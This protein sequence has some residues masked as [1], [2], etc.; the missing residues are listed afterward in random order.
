M[1]AWGFYYCRDR[2]ADISLRHENGTAV[3]IIEKFGKLPGSVTIEGGVFELQLIINGR[4]DDIR[5][6]YAVLYFDEKSEHYKTW[7]EVGSWYNPFNGGALQGFLFL[8][9]NI[10]DQWDLAD[11]IKECTNFL[12]E[13]VP[14]SM[15]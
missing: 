1:Q 14:G 4:A 2:P 10:S 6:V 5:L 9:E 12:Y 8:I 13:Y 7:K 15:L 11:A 3:D